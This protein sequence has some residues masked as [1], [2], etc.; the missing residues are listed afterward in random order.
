VREELAWLA[1]L[2]EDALE[3]DR[4]LGVGLDLARIHDRDLWKYERMLE[5]LDRALEADP[6]DW[7]ALVY[8]GNARSFRIGQADLAA[9]DYRGALALRDDPAVRANLEQLFREG[10]P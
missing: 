9:S 5:E 2:S 4:W 6:R 1:G 8:R 10:G 3:A 7:R